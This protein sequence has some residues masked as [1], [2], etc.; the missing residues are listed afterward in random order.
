MVWNR[1]PS[2]CFYFCFTLQISQHFSPLRSG[3]EWNSESFLFRGIAGI[4]PEQ[5]NCFVNSAFRGIIFLSEIANPRWYSLVGSDVNKLLARA[6]RPQQAGGLSADQQHWWKFRGSLYSYVVCS[7]EKSQH[8]N[9]KPKEEG[10][11]K[12]EYFS[13]QNVTKITRTRLW[14]SSWRLKL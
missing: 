7:V 13:S 11:N 3:S 1:I 14:I 8:Q 10:R 12:W 6:C 4:P 2:V 9:Q 5:A